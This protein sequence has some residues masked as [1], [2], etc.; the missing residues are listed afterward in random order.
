M[1]I[2]ERGTEQ[3]FAFRGVLRGSGCGRKCVHPN[4]FHA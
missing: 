4:H 1:S 2:I 3:V